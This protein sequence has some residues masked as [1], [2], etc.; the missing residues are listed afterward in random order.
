MKRH[1]TLVAIAFLTLRTVAEGFEG[2]WTSADFNAAAGW[3]IALIYRWS[4][5]K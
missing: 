2:G 4:I 3:A 5:P 1:L